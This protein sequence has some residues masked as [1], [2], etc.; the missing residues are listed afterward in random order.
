MV[1]KIFQIILIIAVACIGNVLDMY[2]TYEK[3]TSLTIPE[4][5]PVYTGPLYITGGAFNKHYTE[6]CAPTQLGKVLSNSILINAD[7]GAYDTFSFED[8]EYYKVTDKANPDTFYVMHMN[9]QLHGK[10]FDIVVE[11]RE[12]PH[13]NR[14]IYLFEE[15]NRYMML[16]WKDKIHVTTPLTKNKI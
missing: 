12:G 4:M 11:L 10:N 8:I 9:S 16:F 7:S 13:Y 15:G 2:G 14:V 1:N 6:K 5:I 3:D